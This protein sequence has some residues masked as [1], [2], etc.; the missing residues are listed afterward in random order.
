MPS[1]KITPAIGGSTKASAHLDGLDT[2]ILRKKG[3]SDC[4]IA[5]HC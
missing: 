3:H 1:V 2:N 5:G 4:D